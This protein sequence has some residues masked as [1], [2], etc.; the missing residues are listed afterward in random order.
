MDGYVFQ[1]CSQTMTRSFLLQ[2]QLSILLTCHIFHKLRP[3]S[4]ID[5]GN[6]HCYCLLIVSTHVNILNLIYIDKRS[7][8]MLNVHPHE[9]F[10]RTVAFSHMKLSRMKIWHITN[11]ALSYESF[12]GIF[13]LIKSHVKFSHT[14]KFNEQK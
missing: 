10:I 11:E 2:L 6:F 5:C 8:T 9:N 4:Q 7:L 13:S 14:N 1:I 3:P 12:T